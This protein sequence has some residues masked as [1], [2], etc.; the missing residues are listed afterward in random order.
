MFLG[1]S[2]GTC[3]CGTPTFAHVPSCFLPPRGV[4]VGWWLTPGCYRFTVCVTL[5]FCSTVAPY[6]VPP[7]NV[8]SVSVASTGGTWYGETQR[9]ERVYRLTG[10]VTLADRVFDTL[11]TLKHA[12]AQARS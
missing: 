7:L 12:F 8:T 11:S 10:I 4:V 9:R 5:F 1:E 3:A 2:F 6:H